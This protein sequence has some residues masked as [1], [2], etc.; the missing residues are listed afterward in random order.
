VTWDVKEV[1]DEVGRGK[2]PCVSKKFSECCQIYVL[3]RG[4]LV[5]GAEIKTPAGCRVVDVSRNLINH[6]L[7][8]LVVVHT[9]EVQTNH[10]FI[11][12]HGVRSG[13]PFEYADINDLFQRL[14]RKT[15]IDAHADVF[16]SIS[17]MPLLSR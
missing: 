5:N 4:Q 11:K 8:Y 16:G 7:D 12:L 15:R 10:L 1:D 6:I 17:T 13:Q 2:R 9:D 3:D 14:K